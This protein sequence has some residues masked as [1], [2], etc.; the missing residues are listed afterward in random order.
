MK[1]ILVAINLEKNAPKLVAKAEELAKPFGAKIWLL[2]VTEPDPDSFI[3]LEAGPQFAQEKRVAQR[4]READLVNQLK[5]DLQQKNF[6]VDGL[7]IEGPTVKTIKKE[8]QKLNADL[9]I[10]GHQKKNFFYE[11]FVGKLEHDLIDDLNV[12]VLLVPVL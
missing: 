9:V 4:K 12:P 3:G 8:V 5:R 6:E 11:L 1:N 2:H 10:A 7:V